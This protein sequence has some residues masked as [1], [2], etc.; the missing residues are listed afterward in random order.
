MGWGEPDPMAP[1]G[2][3]LITVSGPAGSGKSFLTLAA[4]WE[5][6]ERGQFDRIIIT[7]PMVEV[8]TSLGFLP[9]TLEEKISPW[10]GPIEDNLRAIVQV[11]NPEEGRGEKKGHPEI[12]ASV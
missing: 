7:R 4:A 8:G 5:R 6:L 3:R 11:P 2:V 10:G 9:G 12:G 1:G